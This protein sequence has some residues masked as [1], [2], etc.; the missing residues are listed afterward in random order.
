MAKKIKAKVRLQLKG[1]AAT[2][3]PPVGNNLGQHGVK[4]MDFCKAFNAETAN[5]KGETVPVVVTI[6]IDNSFDFITKTPLA[7]ELILKKV[8]ITKGAKKSGAEQVGQ[9]K[10]HDITEIAKL[11]LPDLNTTSLEQAEKIVAGTARSMGIKVID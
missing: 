11:K 6:Y 7:S 1:A 3:A 2:P 4:I 9:I 5:R 10:H 8:G